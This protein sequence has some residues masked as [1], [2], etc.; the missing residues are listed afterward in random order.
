[1]KDVLTSE[2]IKVCGRKTTADTIQQRNLGVDRDGIGSSEGKQNHFK[3][4]KQLDTEGTE[5]STE[6]AREQ[7]RKL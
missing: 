5:K 7:Q 2:A 4:W 3:E 1:M 6:P